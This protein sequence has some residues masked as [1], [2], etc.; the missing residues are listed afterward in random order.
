MIS[1]LFGRIRFFGILLRNLNSFTIG[2]WCDRIV[3]HHNR[4]WYFGKEA[5]YLPTSVNYGVLFWGD[6]TPRIVTTSRPHGLEDGDVV[7]YYVTYAKREVHSIKV[8]NATRYQINP[9]VQSVYGHL[10]TRKKIKS[11]RYQVEEGQP[12]EHIKEGGE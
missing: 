5:P 3:V 8:I 9:P 12:S 11:H 2:M 7:D 4:R 6:E 10:W 1:K